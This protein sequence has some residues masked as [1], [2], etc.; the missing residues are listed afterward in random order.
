MEIKYYKLGTLR[1]PQNQIQERKG[2][3]DPKGN[4]G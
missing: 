2:N 1:I 4:E 3:F